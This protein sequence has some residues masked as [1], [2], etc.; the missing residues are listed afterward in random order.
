VCTDSHI[1][2]IQVTVA[3]TYSTNKD[4]FRLVK[5]GLPATFRKNRKWY[6]LF[7]TED[8]TAAALQ[9][10]RSKVFDSMYIQI[11]TAF[12]DISE[13][14]F[15]SRDLKRAEGPKVCLTQG[16][17]GQVIVIDTSGMEIET[18]SKG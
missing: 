18:V 10:T 7:I 2:T 15:T 11:Y 16:L 4:G 3:S 12:L 9:C 6:H 5:R 8:D 1:I 13:L 17:S 14:V